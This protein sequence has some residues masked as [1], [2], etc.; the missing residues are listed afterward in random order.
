MQCKH[1]PRSTSSSSQVARVQGWRTYTGFTQGGDFLDDVVCPGCAGV[2][3]PE[4]LTWDATC[5]TC[6]WT[7]TDMFVDEGLPILP[8]TNVQ[9]LEAELH[10]HVCER[11]F[12]VRPPGSERW[13]YH[14]SKDYNE[15]VEHWKAP[16]PPAPP[17][18]QQAIDT[19]PTSP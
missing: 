2:E 10:D 9:S 1:C 13:V 15:L 3:E 19:T 16:P 4:P 18:S 6:D 17:A 8:I 7:Y 14:G 5:L 12:Q 11:V